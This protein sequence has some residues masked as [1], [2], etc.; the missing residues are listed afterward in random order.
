MD[1]SM[2]SLEALGAQ[3]DRPIASDPD[4]AN[5]ATRALG[6]LFL[7]G[8]ALGLLT[9]A[10]PH[11]GAVD[12]GAIAGLA[13]LALAAG[14]VLL[15]VAP[16][17]RTAQQLVVLLGTGLITAALGF[18]GQSIDAFAFLYLWVV[19]YTAYFLS[20]RE[21]TAQVVAVGLAYAGLLAVTAGNDSPKVTTWL[22]AIGSLAV[23]CLLV[24]KQKERVTMLMERLSEAARTDFL[25]G[26]LNRR[27]F[28]ERLSSEL[29]RAE[30]SAQP[31]GLLIGDLDHFKA[32][33]DRLG[34]HGGDVALQRVASLLTEGRRSGDTVARIGGEEFALILPDSDRAGTHASAERLRGRIRAA[35]SGEPVALTISVGAATFP[36][37]G[38]DAESLLRAADDALYAAKERGRDRTG[39]SEPGQ[40]EE[41]PRPALPLAPSGQPDASLPSRRG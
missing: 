13:T 3:D 30:R 18:S 12:E 5:L 7:A 41:F 1:L 20:R 27:G 39:V 24:L 9:L 28:S 16:L 14:G 21:A 6:W 25:T 34:H 22:L 32:I 19:L 29:S 31:V 36:E 40:A 33:N 26:L 15:L 35:F 23:A 17:G 10:L 11:P 2:R 38:P 4:G 37:S 8:G